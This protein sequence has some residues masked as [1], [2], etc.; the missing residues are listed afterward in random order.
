LAQ[1]AWRSATPWDARVAKT[2]AG[3][4]AHATS[5]ACM[6]VCGAI[7]LTTEHR[8]PTYVKRGRI[9]DGLYGGWEQW[10]HEL[11]ARLLDTAAI[12]AAARI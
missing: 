10:V 6:Q 12:P 1:A 2:Y 7:G 4:A 9:L 11:G 3:Y 5:R 8:L